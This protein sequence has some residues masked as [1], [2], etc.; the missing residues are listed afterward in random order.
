MV[1]SHSEITDECLA[2]LAGY[3]EPVMRYGV[4]G[5]MGHLG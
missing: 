3:I 2:L 4:I 1:L 5:Y